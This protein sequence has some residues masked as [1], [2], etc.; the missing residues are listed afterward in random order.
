MLNR[1]C[2]SYSEAPLLL[3]L[4]LAV[5]APIACTLST[6][7]EVHPRRASC[8]NHVGIE[9]QCRNT[10]AAAAAAGSSMITWERGWAGRV[11]DTAV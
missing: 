8:S 3:P 6:C 7:S 2:C 9:C 11:G 5:W 1:C 10:E 4:L